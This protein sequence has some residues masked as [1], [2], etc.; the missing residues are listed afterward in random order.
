MLLL[1]KIPLNAAVLA[2]FLIRMFCVDSMIG[3][4]PFYVKYFPFLNTIF[5]TIKNINLYFNMFTRG[6]S[7]NQ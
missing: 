6:A 3:L 4:L 7:W 1:R 5:L 2:L